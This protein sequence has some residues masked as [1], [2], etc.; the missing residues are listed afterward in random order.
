MSRPEHALVSLHDCAYLGI[1]PNRDGV[2]CLVVRPKG[3]RSARLIEIAL[4]ERVVIGDR[5]WS[6]AADDW[7][8]NRISALKQFILGGNAPAQAQASQVRSK[9]EGVKPLWRR[10][11]GL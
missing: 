4:V 11:L 3:H 1:E 7:Y 10:L 8:E 9:A 6:S 2:M 5:V